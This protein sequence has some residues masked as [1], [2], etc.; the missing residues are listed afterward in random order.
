MKSIH[1]HHPQ[2][3]YRKELRQTPNRRACWQPSQ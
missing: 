1:Y 2:Q 3:E